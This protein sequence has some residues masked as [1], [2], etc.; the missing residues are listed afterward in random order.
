MTAKGEKNRTGAGWFSVVLSPVYLPVSSTLFGLTWIIPRRRGGENGLMK[1]S[2]SL[3]EPRACRYVYRACRTNI[4]V[5]SQRQQPLAPILTRLNQSNIHETRATYTCASR[6]PQTTRATRPAENGYN[7]G[8]KELF[9]LFPL[10]KMSATSF[11]S[12]RWYFSL[13]HFTCAIMSINILTR[14]NGDWPCLRTCRCCMHVWLVIHIIT[15]V[16]CFERHTGSRWVIK[17]K[18]LHKVNVAIWMFNTLIVNYCR[19]IYTLKS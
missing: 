10:F 14:A 5:A 19:S 1:L 18:R 3:S 6:R 7:G 8:N 2:L 11:N 9:S 4:V 13:N 15:C 17:E 12:D 16:Y